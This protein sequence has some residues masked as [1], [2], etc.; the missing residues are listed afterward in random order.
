MGAIFTNIKI[1]DIMP[2]Y[3][4]ICYRELNVRVNI[5]DCFTFIN[6][7]CKFCLILSF[8]G[9]SNMFNLTK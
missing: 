7:I 6:L 5:N 2:R 4:N 1:R 3:R 9:G 8:T